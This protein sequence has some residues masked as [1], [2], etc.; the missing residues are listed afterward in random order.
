VEKYADALSYFCLLPL[1]QLLQFG[2][3]LLD[4]A[5]LDKFLS[6]A[7]QGPE[8]AFQVAQSLLAADSFGHGDEA[9]VF[10][11]R[12]YFIQNAYDRYLTHY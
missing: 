2:I 5:V 1:Q 12:S 6:Y 7:L 8:V 11:D 9:A 3:L 4:G 10:A